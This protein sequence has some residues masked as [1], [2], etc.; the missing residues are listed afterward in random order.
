MLS[1]D[2]PTVRWATFG[3]QVELWV[4]SDIGQ[5]FVTR[6]TKQIQEA[7][8]ELKRADPFKPE[9]IMKAQN[10]I[11]VG[12]QILEALREA[13]AVGHSALEELRNAQN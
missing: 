2:D 3:R 8:E 7:T 12:E 1:P 4:E 13:I 10:R 6:F 9:E 5:F 11:A